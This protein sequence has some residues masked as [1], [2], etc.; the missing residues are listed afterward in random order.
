MLQ[1]S[2]VEFG[3]L[4]PLRIADGDR[5]I[6]LPRQKHR[7][8]LAFLVLHAGELISVD[9]L[10]DELWGERPPPTAKNSL[11]NYVSHL[12]KALGPDVV[13]TRPPG[14]L[15]DI[16]P[17]D[18][19]VYRFLR[20]LDESRE[21][22]PPAR[23]TTLRRA[24]GL[25]RGPA[26]ADLEFEPFALAEAPRLEELRAT[27]EEDLVA[28]ELE[29]ARH[30]ELV[31]RIE[32]LIARN[33]LRE[34]L[35]GQLM[36]ALYR[37]GRQAEALAAYKQA[38]QTLVEELGIEPGPT[39]RALEQAVL[40]QDA[41]LGE[42]AA[43]EALQLR[44]A[45][46]RERR[47]TVTVLFAE[48]DTP[49]GLD[50]ERSR[51]LTTRAFHELR[52]ATEY[53][54]GTVERLAGDELMAVF[55]IPERHEDDALRAVRAA[56]QIRRAA[57]SSQE[58]ELRVALVTGEVV[59]TGPATRAP[60]AGAPV[61]IAKRV[62]EVAPAGDVIVNAA[63]IELV[64][65]A[66]VAKPVGPVALRGRADPVPLFRIDDVH[67]TAH[68]PRTAATP[69]IGRKRELDDLRSVFDE[70]IAARR[71][72]VLTVLGEAGVGKTRLAV[73]VAETLADEA[74]L[75]VGRCVSYG[76]GATWLPLRD[77][78]RQVDLRAV[79]EDEA[80]DR[81]ETLFAG[82]TVSV[83]DAFWAARR[84]VEALARERPALIVL[85]DL[86]W[87]AP[88]FLDFVEQLAESPVESPAL[89]LCLARPELAAERPRLASFTLQPLSDTD[90]R[91]LVDAAS[92][93]SVPPEARTRIAEVAEGNPLFAEQLLAY[94][95][96]HGPA[97][98]ATVPPTIDA[99]LA[100]RLDR[101]DAEERS[102]LQRAA[103][104]GR[105][106]WH[107][108]VLHL[109]PQ[110]E[111]P[112]V[113]RHLDEL[114]RKGL[115]RA[116]RSSS[117]RE[118][119]FRFHHVLIRDVA[120]ASI[121]KLERADLHEGVAEWLDAGGDPDDE[122]VGYHLER[123]YLLLAELG[124]VDRHAR[125][126]ATDAGERLGAAGITA[127]KRAD[128]PAAANLLGRAATLLPGGHPTR[129]QA[130]CELGVALRVYGQAEEGEQ[131]LDDAI[132][133]A[134]RRGDRVVE[135]RARLEL[136]AARVFSSPE[137]AGEALVQ[138]GSTAIPVF[139]QA[140][141]DR[142]LGRAWLNLAIVHGSLHC[143]NREWQEAAERAL[144]HYSRAGWPATT[145]RQE[146]A[147][148]LYN[149][150]TPVREAIARCRKLARGAD[151]AGEASVIVVI[152]GLE[153]MRGRPGVGLRLVE[154]AQTVLEELGLA[155]S[156]ATSALWMAGQIALSQGAYRRAE[157]FLRATCERHMAVSNLMHFATV[158]AEL[159]DVLYMQ[160]AYEEA[161]EWVARA[162]VH[163]ATDDVSAQF[164]WR[165]VRAKLLARDGS[166][167]EAE[168]L[169]DRARS[170]A[171]GTDSLNQHAK[172]LLD[173]AEVLRL[174]E[175]FT[176][177]AGSAEAASRLFE[178]K[179][180]VAALRRVQA[181]LD[182]LSVA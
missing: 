163:A 115:V 160:G 88:T 86:H 45:D 108:S 57:R 142:A 33:P 43:R 121:P 116:G 30:G 165:S 68:R 89:V 169:V 27:V 173:R 99:L 170:L 69:L 75:A 22:A 168:D 35:W 54:G 60:T 102:V 154:Q 65:G 20:L 113:G 174:A 153:A 82:G 162:Q 112:G 7:A 90:A 61:T 149:G 32:E 109:T 164:W 83:A 182:E 158:A 53:H 13:R 9:R 179:G 128:A 19:D 135:L 95:K 120:Y 122:I 52:A 31:P 84:F 34:R 105:E 10:L 23:A 73:E 111:V 133:E 47:A 28:A 159:A 42:V 96:E 44:P 100:S 106:F 26:L 127:W 63:T 146:I 167:E 176:A 131:V 130:L 145:C 59:L 12:R 67:E 70:A 29:L 134:D 15:L 151:R 156:V 143:R 21:Q 141:D 24:L 98:L 58:L 97:A 25:W 172:V 157:A 11:H 72:S 110:L 136:A 91:K 40:R 180:N 74:S 79:L 46:L 178:T 16:A 144:D 62:A 51:T 36:V 103:V 114:A 177:A 124:A 94:A 55:G 118:D 38:R 181:L 87:A 123:A 126:L 132:A 93:E 5:E 17:D 117:E 101:L 66:V 138:I 85:E 56:L 175:R 150:P 147:A 155:Q 64:Q 166:L 119:A 161:A 104:V 77:L 48:V 81:L 92:D 140:G 2:W 1:P 37:S 71:T 125:R 171:A 14:Y 3:V 8:L 80:A 50:V 129:A 39:L 41:A 152:G 139:E 6:L 4:G 78:A 137:G 18:V 76:E 49:G 148:A 107:A